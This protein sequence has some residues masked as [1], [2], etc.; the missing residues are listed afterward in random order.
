MYIIV[1]NTLFIASPADRKNKGQPG[2]V[3]LTSYTSDFS[4]TLTVSAL[5]VFN[6]WF[7]GRLFHSKFKVL[8]RSQ[9]AQSP[10]PSFIHQGLSASKVQTQNMTF[11]RLCVSNHS[12]Y[13][14]YFDKEIPHSVKNILSFIHF[15]QLCGVC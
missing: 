7:R 14:M 13:A 8:H 6:S 2:T 3:S 15:K 10:F 9:V 12:W 11:L 5:S 1:S 4:S